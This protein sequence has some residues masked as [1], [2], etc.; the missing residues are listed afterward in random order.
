MGCRMKQRHI[1]V[2]NVFFSP[3]S[4]GGATVVAEQVAAALVRFGTHQVSA[5]SLCARSDLEPYCV[6]KSQKNGIDNYLINVPTHRKYAEMYQNPEITQRLSELIQALEP[7]LV[8]AHC[9]QEIGTGIITSANAANVPVILSVHDFW[10]LCERQ[11]MVRPDEKYCE[12]DPIQI[13]RCRGCVGN[14]WAAKTR[15]DH[16]Q[17]VGSKVACVT[18]PSQF[19]KD[20]SE[21]SGFA[22]GKGLVWTNGVQ[23]PG[24][25][26]EKKQAARRLRDPRVCFGY[27]GGPASI[28]GWLGIRAALQ[29]LEHSNFRGL[30]VDGSLDASWWAQRDLMAI[31]GEWE[32]YQRFE[33]ADMD[34]F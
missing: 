34:D 20:L 19:A 2:V 29:D 24:P 12:Q 8:H 26:F 4:Y 28:K 5:V 6:I 30:V 7:D 13:D 1:L 23:L 33:E 16:L 15:F 10:W 11:F 32:I 22:T 31:A 18:Y 21:A 27:V 14:Y 9:L 17:E 3:F 25:G